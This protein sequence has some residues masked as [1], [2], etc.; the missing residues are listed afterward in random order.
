[1]HRKTLKH[2]GKSTQSATQSREK[3]VALLPGVIFLSLCLPVTLYVSRLLGKGL[4]D[5]W[6]GLQITRWLTQANI[7]HVTALIS[8]GWRLGGLLANLVSVRGL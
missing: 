6:K 7:W 2:G 8:V 1:M 3:K 5:A 4:H